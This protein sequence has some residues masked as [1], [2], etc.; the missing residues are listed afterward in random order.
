VSS[1]QA[2]G[3]VFFAAPDGLKLHALVAGPDSVKRLPVVCLPGLARTVEDFRELIEALVTDP[4]PRR[5]LALDARGRGRSARDPNPENYAVP[6]ELGDVLAVLDA[7]GID[8]AVFVGT[9]RGGILTM[10]LAA[11]RAGAIAG[12]VLNDIGPDIDMTGVMRIKGYV[13]RLP[14]PTSYVDAANLLRGAMG[15]QFPGW[16]D[17]AWESYA[18]RTW[19]DVGG[20]LQARYDSALSQALAAIGPET[21]MPSLWAQFDAL[22]A[23]PLMVIRGEHSDLLSRATVAAMR[24]R[25]PD[26]EVLEVRGQGHAPVLT[27]AAIVGAIRRFVARCDPAT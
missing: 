3:S 1:T 23:V 27:G 10:T 18:R 26:L 21:P 16:D 5:V 17:A 20:R 4:A 11:V 12:A 9:S 6:V 13:G 19:E 24:A 8:R 25:R 2:I 14:R 22:P 7:S 15:D